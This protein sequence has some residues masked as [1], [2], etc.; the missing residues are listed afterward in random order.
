MRFCCTIWYTIYRDISDLFIFELIFEIEI[1]MEESGG[2]NDA[3][4]R[5]ALYKRLGGTWESKK[6]LRNTGW[7]SCAVLP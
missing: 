4:R 7:L 1:D 5:Y 6:I 2:L 3:R